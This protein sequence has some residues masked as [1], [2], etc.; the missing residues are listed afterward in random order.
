MEQILLA[1]GHQRNRRSRN[2]IQQKHE[3]KSSLTG[4]RHTLFWHCNRYSAWVYTCTIPVHN[5]PRLLT[6][7]VNRFNERKCFTLEKP[8]S[9]Q[10]PHTNYHGH[11]LRWWHSASDKYTHP[12]QNPYCIV[13]RKQQMGLTFHINAEKSE[14][15]RFNPNQRGNISTLNGGSLKLVDKFTYLG[16][17]VSSTKNN[18]S[19][20]LPKAR[21][22]FNTSSVIW[23]SKPIR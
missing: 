12:D 6:S 5:L 1:Y 14:Y 18:I 13:W 21:A 11:G 10:I 20:R 15:M 4:W 2:D 19:M 8:R 22:A 3:S 7:N 9:R 17:S 16:S 23:K